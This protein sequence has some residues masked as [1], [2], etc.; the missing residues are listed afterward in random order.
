[1]FEGFLHLAYLGPGGPEF[2]MIMLVLLVLFG[3]KD[4]PRILRKINEIINQVR[5]TADSFK[6]EV[7]YG[8][9]KNDPP[10]YSDP[11][12]Y[13]EDHDDDYS[14]GD[15]EYYDDDDKERDYSDNTFQNLEKDLEEAEPAVD[16]VVV[17]ES[18]DSGS[19]G[20]AVTEIE[21]D[22]DRKD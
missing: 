18:K 21:E 13:G 17:E 6:R 1:M 10:S 14:Y 3:A 12:E 8:D 19:E 7:M 4:A 22:D 16:D 15:E 5:N 11:D 2:M 20:N 9:I